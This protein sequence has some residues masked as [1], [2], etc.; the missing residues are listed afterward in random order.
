MGS[1]LGTM[2][3]EQLRRSVVT[4][5][6]E[7]CY[8][9]NFN[10]LLETNKKILKGKETMNYTVL[11]IIKC[12]RKCCKNGEKKATVLRLFNINYVQLTR[13]S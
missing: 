2:S 5:V 13:R 6:S 1:I 8:F 3:S 4:N 9:L 11:C 10:V 12:Y 7:S